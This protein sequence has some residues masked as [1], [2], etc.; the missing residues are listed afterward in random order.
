MTNSNGEGIFS[1]WL[2]GFNDEVQA[3]INTRILQMAGMGKWSDKWVSSLIDY[4][5]LFEIRITYKKVQY[6]PLFCYGPKQK[7]LTL[8]GGAVEKGG[9]LHRPTLDG[10]LKKIE[11]I[12]NDERWIHEYDYS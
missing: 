11:L 5:K 2:Q 3:V 9:K 10:A 12:K 7:S 8:L 1:K 4:P 6:R